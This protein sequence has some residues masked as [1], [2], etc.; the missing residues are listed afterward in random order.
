[1]N[2]KMGLS[3][4]ALGIACNRT[5]T[6][7]VRQGRFTRY[8]VSQCALYR[9]HLSERH[10]KT[11]YLPARDISKTTIQAMFVYRHAGGHRCEEN[12]HFS[13]LQLARRFSLQVV[14]AVHTVLPCK[15]RVRPL[16]TPVPVGEHSEPFPLTP[17]TGLS[18]IFTNHHWT[19]DEWRRLQ[20]T[21]F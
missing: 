17:L 1:M 11:I 3:F 5:G 20:W 7:L 15:V 4:C 16:R 21:P 8:W 18:K 2:S 9:H 19:F 12:R 14:A 6:P 13:F 10:E